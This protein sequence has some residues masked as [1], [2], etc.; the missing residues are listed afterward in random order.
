LIFIIVK[1]QSVTSRKSLVQTGC[2]R[3]QMQCSNFVSGRAEW[4]LAHPEFGN[5]VNPI[6]PRE[7][8]YAQHITACPLGFE[9][10]T[11]SL[12]FALFINISSVVEF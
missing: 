12:Q 6:Q 10:L 11:A 1:K 9:I 7:A 3:L 8:D 5:L 2:F 4:S